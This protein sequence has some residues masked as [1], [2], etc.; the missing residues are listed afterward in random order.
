[1]IRIDTTGNMR[2]IVSWLHRY[3]GLAVAAVLVMSGCTGALITFNG[4]IDRVTH[5][6][7]RAVE[8]QAAGV[9]ADTLAAGARQA[10]SRDP[11]RMIVFPGSPRDAVEIWYRGSGMRAYLD[12]HD[13]RVLGVRDMRD[14]PM[15]F[16]VDLHTNLLSGE[17]GRS[18]IGWF[19]LATVALIVLGVWLWWPRRGR[20]RAALTVKWEA[21][22]ARV[23]LDMHKVAG[24]L[25][26]VFLLVIAVTGV[27]LALP[28][29]VTDPLLAAVTGE[30]PTRAAPASSRR[31][32]PAASLDTMIR[33]ARTT[34]PQ[35][36][37][38]RLMMP[39]SPQGA[40]TIRMR[41]PGEV[42]QLGRTFVFFDRYDGTLLRA[43]SVF[44][45]NLATRIHA[46]FYPLH[47][48]F[49]GGVATRLLNILFGMALTLI[50]VSGCWMWVRNRLARRRAARRHGPVP[51]GD[52]AGAAKSG[53]A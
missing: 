48:G 46:W 8:P 52:P 28:G 30:G 17:A 1:M 26:G 40:V 20:W 16:L 44:K 22:P 37:I 10:W 31:A 24:A 32:G 29:V 38:T 47:T 11:V 2:K 39:A 36:T 18:V 41:L 42:H 35:G 19:G 5:P 45:A 43:D 15:G 53:Q 51:G 13:G 21:G 6:G 33:Q 25:T 49:Y 34:F 12:P 9:G 23:W 4:E 50:S 14:S 7:L 27:A 3:V